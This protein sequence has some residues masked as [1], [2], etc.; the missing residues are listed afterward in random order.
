MHDRIFIY[1]K[2]LN[3][4]LKFLL[5][6]KFL[7]SLLS[8][9]IAIGLKVNDLKKKRE[10]RFTH[11]YMEKIFY[12]YDIPTLAYLLFLKM[13]PN[14]TYGKINQFVLH[15]PTISEKTSLCV[16]H[17]VALSICLHK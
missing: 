17:R 9:L 16:Q 7:S 8:T 2:I 12:F 15:K 4:P 11:V 6:L 14:F 13:S 10:T 3:Y 1:V 5:T